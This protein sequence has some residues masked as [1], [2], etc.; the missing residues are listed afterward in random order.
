MKREDF[1]EGG[2]TRGSASRARQTAVETA[3][4]PALRT[5]KHGKGALLVGGI[6]GNRGGPGRPKD[7]LR[8]QMRADLEAGLDSIRADLRGERLS[9][10]ALHDVLHDERI[11]ALG[12]DVL[13]ILGDVLPYHLTA[14]LSARDRTMAV[15][16]LS[17][18]GLGQENSVETKGEGVRY[19]IKIPAR[20]STAPAAAPVAVLPPPGE[21][22]TE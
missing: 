1:A 18:Y 20:V 16:V 8:A 17:K 14:R 5:P 4:R 10:M 2:L 19:V 3:T 11:I 12:P 9:A 7:E 15:E 21:P 22:S 13:E 6:P